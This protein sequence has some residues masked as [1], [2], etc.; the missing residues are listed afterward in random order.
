MYEP[1]PLKNFFTPLLSRRQPSSALK[2]GLTQTLVSNIRIRAVKSREYRLTVKEFHLFTSGLTSV[3]CDQHKITNPLDFWWHFNQILHTWNLS[4][5]IAS[6]FA[7]LLRHLDSFYS[8]WII[9][10]YGVTCHHNSWLIIGHY[11]LASIFICKIF[12]LFL[13][14]Y[15]NCVI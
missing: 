9:C 8:I 2:F 12:N 5:N 11:F 4:H 3:F 6:I 7:C 14:W 15:F 1:K 13:Y 10:L